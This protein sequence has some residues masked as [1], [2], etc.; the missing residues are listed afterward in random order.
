MAGMIEL[1]VGIGVG[2][3]DLVLDDEMDVGS[4]KVEVGVVCCCYSYLSR[5]ICAIKTAPVSCFPPLFDVS[6]Q[7][8]LSRVNCNTPAIFEV[9]RRK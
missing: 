7:I 3:G 5:Q 9:S 1:C 8:K 2:V 6:R 4:G